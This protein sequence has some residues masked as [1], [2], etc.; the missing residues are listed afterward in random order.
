MTNIAI[1][2]GHKNSEFSHE[3]NG[4]FHGKM[5][6]HQRVVVCF[7]FNGLDPQSSP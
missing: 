6:V 7:W 4:D 2:H 5:L 1:E 3:K